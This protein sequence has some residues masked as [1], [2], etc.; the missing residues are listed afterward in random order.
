[1]N[2]GK[3][4]TRAIVFTGHMIDAPGRVEARF[5]ASAE[6]R[7]RSAIREAVTAIARERTVG[8]S[9]GASGGDLLF[10]E[11]CEELE[12]PTQ[13]CLGVPREEFVRRS[14]EKAGPDWVRRFESLMERLGTDRLFV[15]PPEAGGENV[16]ARANAWMLRRAE[17]LAS[18]RVLL[19]LWD[20]RGGDGPGGTETM[21]QAAEGFEVRVIAMAS[22]TKS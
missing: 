7:V 9:A 13:V 19:A 6:A 16:W 4:F 22:L 12:V 17:E 3:L 10:Q 18:E 1:M 21:I 15:L 8:I 2:E 5:P 14:V 11:V 20:G